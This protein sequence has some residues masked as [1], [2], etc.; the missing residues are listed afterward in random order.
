MPNKLFARKSDDDLPGPMEPLDEGEPDPIERE[1]WG[2]KEKEKLVSGK[3]SRKKTK[4]KLKK[5]KKKRKAKP[6]K[7]TG[8]TE[9][10]K[11]GEEVKTGLPVQKYHRGFFST[12]IWWLVLLPLLLVPV[13]GPL[14]TFTLIPF[15]AGRR[16]SRWVE[17]R[18]AMEIGF[19][20][21]V[22]VSAF[23]IFLLYSILDAFTTGTVNEVS[24]QGRE[25]LI[26]ALGVGCNLGFCLLGTATGTI[27]N[28]RDSIP[29]KT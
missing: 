14:F 23:Q 17:K 16:G 13:I 3:E 19:L 28:F 29:K 26:L 27:K 2:K 7:K 12:I 15:I 6:Q 10:E 21:S 4:A 25:Y 5:I 11:S 1:P 20:A 24:T 9:P 18:Y 22:V 8:K